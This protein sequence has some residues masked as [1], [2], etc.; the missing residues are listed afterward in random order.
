[1]NEDYDGLLLVETHEDLNKHEPGNK[2]GCMTVV[3]ALLAFIL[4]FSASFP[5]LRF[6]IRNNYDQQVEN[7]KVSVCENLSD[8]GFNDMTCDL[9]LGIAEFVPKVF[10]IGHSE[11]RIAAAMKGYNLKKQIAVSQ[12]GCLNPS[13][14]TYLVAKSFIGW[15]TEVAFLFCSDLL[16]ERTVLVDG[17]PIRRPTY[18]F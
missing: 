16:V 1:M 12:P 2:K 8:A 18:D 7:F 11:G 15:K 6:I 5:L 14:L 3:A 13:L 9:S 10:S 4:V 17:A